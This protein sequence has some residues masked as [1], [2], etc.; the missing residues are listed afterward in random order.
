[1][2]LRNVPC[3]DIA[4]VSYWE[5]NARWH[6]LWINHTDYHS[7][8]IS[9]LMKRVQPHWSIL[10]IGAG[11]GVLSLPLSA[12]GCRVTAVEPSSEM[13][14]LLFERA[15]SHGIANLEIEE[16]PWELL[17]DEREY[18]LV[19][20]CNIMHLT[21]GLT[22][23]NKLCGMTP[24]HIILVH[25]GKFRNSGLRLI[26]DEYVQAAEKSFIINSPYVYHSYA[27][28]NDHHAFRIGRVPG[29]KETARFIRQ[30]DRR[31]GHYWIDEEVS[32][33]ATWWTRNDL[34]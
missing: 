7:R 17:S 28:A 33:S 9:F 27:E 21:G 1:M 2:A 11:D 20:A 31:V 4:T 16:L 10:D 8:I 25:E 14:K 34:L 18:D 19:I 26:A 32:V 5:Q 12:L 30:L 23:F 24:K 13:R 6:K 3:N 15:L 22:A 29:L